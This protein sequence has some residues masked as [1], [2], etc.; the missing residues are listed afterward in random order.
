MIGMEGTFSGKQPLPYTGNEDVYRHNFSEEADNL[1]KKILA[2]KFH[3][4]ECSLKE[5]LRRGVRS[6]KEY[7]RYSNLYVF[8]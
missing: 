7:F 6:V 2:Q 5:Y 3:F 8:T 4:Q 1:H